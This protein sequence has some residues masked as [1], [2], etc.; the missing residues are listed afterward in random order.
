MPETV[1]LVCYGCGA[2]P[3]VPLGDPAGVVMGGW[4]A[5][6][7]TQGRV[8]ELAV[9]LEEALEEALARRQAPLGHVRRGEG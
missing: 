5:R 1:G 2:K 3:T 4:C 8:S 7:L 6:C 9:D